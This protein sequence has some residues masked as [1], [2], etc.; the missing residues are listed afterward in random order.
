MLDKTRDELQMANAL[1]TLWIME[2]LSPFAMDEEACDFIIDKL[3][4]ALDDFKDARK[5]EEE[6]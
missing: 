3:G 1:G 5:E 6:K 2:T 4:D